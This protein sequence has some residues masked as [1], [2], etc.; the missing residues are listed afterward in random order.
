MKI[1]TKKK[2]AISSKMELCFLQIEVW[3]IGSEYVE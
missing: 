1:I 2:I 3:S